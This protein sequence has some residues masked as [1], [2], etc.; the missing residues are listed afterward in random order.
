MLVAVDLGGRVG[1]AAAGIRNVARTCAH[2]FVVL[3]YGLNELT[4]AR[5]DYLMGLEV[6]AKIVQIPLYCEK[7]T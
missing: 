7:I 4:Q 1:W 3:H 5:L 2:T 6:N